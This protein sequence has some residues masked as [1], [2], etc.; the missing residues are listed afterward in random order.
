MSVIFTKVRWKNF[1]S[2]GSHFTEIDLNSHHMTLIVGANGAGKSQ[3]LDAICFG[4]FNKPFR[5]VN[6]PSVVNSINGKHCVVEVEF[7]TNGKDYKITRGLKPAIFEIW[8]NGICLNQLASSI[9]YQNVLEQNILKTT[10][11]SFTQIVILGSANFTPFMR[12]S[13]PNRRE[14]LD[15]LLDIQVFTS[16][17]VLAKKQLSDLKL[18]MELNNKGIQ[19]QEEK[20]N[21]LKRQIHDLRKNTDEYKQRLMDSIVSAKEKQKSLVEEWGVIDNQI[22]ALNEEEMDETRLL[23]SLDSYK[24][25]NSVLNNKRIEL[26]RHNTFLKENDS[27][28]V[29][30]QEIGNEH[31]DRMIGI[32]SESSMELERALE[33]LKGRIQTSEKIISDILERKKKYSSLK[34]SEKIIKAKL[35]D[36]KE[37]VE[38][39]TFELNKTDQEGI[40]SVLNT[41][42]E[43]LSNAETELRNLI[44]QKQSLADQ[45]NLLEISI[46]ILKD[47]GVKTQ[48][49][50]KYLP[51][52]NRTVNKYLN[53]M[54]FMVD[55]RLDENFNETIMS[56]YRDEFSYENFSEGEKARIDLSL[57]LTFR[58]IAK[59]RNS[60]NTNLL[61]M[62]ETFDS[63]LDSA[64]SDELI[65]IFKNIMKGINIFVISHREGMQNHFDRTLLV[66]KVN[67]YSQIS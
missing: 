63:S 20:I 50:K 58:F 51:I 26:E 30:K 19:N 28:H 61:L 64:G 9:D 5:K 37:F 31:K 38:N 62:D 36:L 15:D 3:L 55:F 4:L 7:T 60:I 32:N 18:E 46:Q 59:K 33:D 21:Y 6:K 66:K 54:D 49:I 29:C 67:N 13:T 16:M 35:T 25:L 53:A 11:K 14:I 44:Q 17:G 40:V 1:L 39:Q 8:E 65:N 12:L 23:K 42:M 45:K 2:T 48:I 43:E 34:S 56:R 47:G 22:K 27:C 52:L 57:M 24:S 41:N 10:F